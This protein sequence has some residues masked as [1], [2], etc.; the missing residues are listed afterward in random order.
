MRLSRG[1]VRRTCVGEPTGPEQSGI[2]RVENPR[3]P[4][5]GPVVLAGRTTL[6]L[7]MRE[8]E[9]SAL[10]E[11]REAAEAGY[12][13]LGCTRGTASVGK[14]SALLSLQLGVQRLESAER[15]RKSPKS[16]RSAPPSL[17]RAPAPLSPVSPRIP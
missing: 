10:S 14:V 15:E 12:T 4:R 17:L 13:S 6:V 16:P 1:Q 7:E 5:G 8:G 2:L 3:S 9:R 11:A